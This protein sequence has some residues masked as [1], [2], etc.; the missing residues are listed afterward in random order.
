MARIHEGG[1]TLSQDYLR[2]LDQGCGLTFDLGHNSG[3][4][5]FTKVD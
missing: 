1:L 5:V 4:T 2:D 3:L